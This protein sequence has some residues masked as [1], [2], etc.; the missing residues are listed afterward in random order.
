VATLLDQLVDEL[1]QHADPV[2]AA[3]ER[4]YLNTGRWSWPIP[5]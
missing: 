5:T 3:Q 2:R 1:H 4:A